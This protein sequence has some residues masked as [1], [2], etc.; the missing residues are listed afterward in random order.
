[1]PLCW[2]SR[3]VVRTRGSPDWAILWE[4]LRVLRAGFPPGRVKLTRFGSEA[5]AKRN[6][7]SIPVCGRRWG[8]PDATGCSGETDQVCCRLNDKSSMCGVA[9]AITQFRLLTGRAFYWSARL[10][11]SIGQQTWRN[12][13]LL[14]RW[15][16]RVS[17]Q[18]RPTVAEEGTGWNHVVGDQSKRGILHQDILFDVKQ[19]SHVDVANS[20]L[21]DLLRSGVKPM[22]CASMDVT[23]ECQ[24]GQS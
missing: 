17:T 21:T 9:P 10:E 16:K 24:Y 5:Q 3:L 7:R 23:H 13:L 2:Q 19:F 8:S 12:V 4:G 15:P 22:H 14:L 11:P 1:M 20:L 18:S 6:E